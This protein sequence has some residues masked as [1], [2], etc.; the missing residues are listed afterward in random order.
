MPK[1]GKEK[2]SRAKNATESYSKKGEKSEEDPSDTESLC[3][4][5]CTSAVEFLIQCEKCKMYLCSDCEKIPESV[6]VSIARYI[7]FARI[8]TR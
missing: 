3:C 6:M 4:D 1:T 2:N 7:G 5:R 8:V